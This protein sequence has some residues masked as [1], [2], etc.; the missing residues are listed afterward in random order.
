MSLIDEMTEEYTII[1]KVETSDGLGGHK[2]EWVDGATIEGAMSFTNSIQGRTAQKQGVSSVYSLYTSRSIVLEYHDVLR[3]SSD[4]KIFRVTSDG[5]DEY[6]PRSAGL[7]LR[8]V[9]CEEWTLP[10]DET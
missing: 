7:D 9:A 6:T 4:G 1:N 8:R 10:E 5:D 3:R 2:T